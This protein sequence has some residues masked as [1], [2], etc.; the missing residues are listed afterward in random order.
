MIL[1]SN[2]KGT[3]GNNNSNDNVNDPTNLGDRSLCYI[4]RFVSR[5]C[6]FQNRFVLD[7]K[8]LNVLY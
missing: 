4:F 8:L 6:Q 1:R 3:V 7:N 5:Q 2:V